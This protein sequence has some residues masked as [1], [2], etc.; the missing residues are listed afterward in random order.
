VSF[1]VIMEEG[2][3]L[4]RS[5]A[6]SSFINSSSLRQLDF[7]SPSR[8]LT[9]SPFLRCI[10]TSLGPI[11]NR[12]PRRSRIP[13]EEETRPDISQRKI[14]IV[15]GWGSQEG[16]GCDQSCCVGRHCWFVFFILKGVSICAD[17]GRF[18]G[19]VGVGR[20]FL[21]AFSSYGEEGV[22]KAL[23]IL[24]VCSQTFFPLAFRRCI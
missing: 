12:S 19:K 5:S 11:R 22:C 13:T 18:L 7:V 23:Q 24:N 21:Y 4:A 8:F 10:Q 17:N 3:P 16:Y 1:S 6:G 20:P 2:E 14:R 9:Q 15:R